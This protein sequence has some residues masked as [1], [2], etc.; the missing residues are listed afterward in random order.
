MLR[1][2]HIYKIM[3]HLQYGGILFY[4]IFWN[5]DLK[6]KSCANFANGICG[7]S[8]PPKLPYFK[9]KQSEFARN[10]NETTYLLG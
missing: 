9:E 7:I 3:Q 4:F 5:H 6:R 8:F 1:I 10:M 2:S